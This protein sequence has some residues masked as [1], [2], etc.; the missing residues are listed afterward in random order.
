MK[1]L[2]VGNELR[3]VGTVSYWEEGDS[4]Q[5]SDLQYRSREPDDP[6]NLKLLSTGN[7]V[8]YVETSADTFNNAKVNR[9]V[10]EEGEEILK[11]FDYAELCI[12]TSISMKNLKVVKTY[13]TTNETSS[14]KGAMTLTCQ[15]DGETVDIR[16]IVLYDA[17]G[18]LVTADR[19]A[20]K[21][22]DVKGIIDCYDGAYQIKVFSVDD[23]IV[24]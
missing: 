18:K 2:S 15:V 5:I 6:K 20:G 22:I 16:T 21:T 23:I 14:S 1:M 8:A 11:S 3:I 17:D 10:I 9:V 4:Y 7:A 24:H 19:F 12:G 13:T